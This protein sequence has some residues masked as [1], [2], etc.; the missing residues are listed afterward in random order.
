MTEYCSAVGECVDHIIARVGSRI[1]LG[2]PI[3]IG[4][5]VP[6]VNELYR[7]ACADSGIELVIVTGLSLSLPRGRSELERRLLGRFVARVFADVPELEYREAQR[8]QALPRNV[9]VIEFF[10]E[11]GASLDNRTTQQDY[12]SSNYT[13]VARDLLARGV[14]V[15]AQ[16]V[17]S[18]GSGERQE[19]SLGSNADVT[20]DLLPQIAA[21]RSAGRDIMLVGEVHPRLP[22]MLG[23]A[24]VAAARFDLLLEHERY[25]Y[26][27]FCPPN[28]PIG[29]VDHALGLQASAL[30][31]DG[32]TLQIG[33]GELGDAIVCALQLRHQQNGAYRQALGDL[34]IESAAPLIDA[35]GGREPFA[36]GLFGCTE[37]LIDQ[38]LDL[39]RC[40]IL[41]RRVYDF[42]PLQRLIERGGL[43]EPFDADVLKGLLEA[44]VPAQLDAA[45]FAALRRYGILAEACRYDTGTIRSPEGVAIEANFG[46][47]QV[48]ARI[49][50]TCLGRRLKGGAVVQAGFFLGPRNF[51]AALHALPEDERALFDMRGVG[52]VNQLY[53]NDYELR[54]LQ[55]RDARFINTT[56]MVTLLGAAVSDTLDDGR[57]V[58]GVGGQYNFVSMA[59][60]LPDARS[61]LCLRA[62]RTQRG[63]TR[64]NIVWNYAQATI[65]RHLRDLVATEYGVA[66]LRSRTD[67]EVIVA[68]LNI[69]D[70]RF[71]EQLQHAAQ[72]SGK[73]A[74]D[75]RIPDQHRNNYPHVLHAALAPH[76][77]AGRFSEFPFGTDFN[78]EEIEL[79][80]ALKFLK[81]STA[82]LTGRIATFMAAARVRHD[83]SYANCLARMSLDRPV[84]VSERVLARLVLLALQRV[85]AQT[86]P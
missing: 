48:R 62:T 45:S 40:G 8:K 74:A 23:Q 16:L 86:L 64:S 60:A 67:S 54:V 76:R 31:R 12:L 32:G 63:Q 69:A 50:Q 78:A 73:L 57:V 65:P 1:V 10:L 51:Y 30:I 39:Y 17:A 41:R 3:G 36:T 18:R 9:Q 7:R 11:P 42:L 2:V 44:G 66:D 83:P 49:A 4:K 43:R 56:M 46:D 5:P 38:M 19:L 29:S 68:L 34:R 22:F 21:A 28:L 52:H 55:R 25:D 84:G 79:T 47:P 20:A 81:G 80:R 70:S 35:I 71:Q 61:L 24:V 59:H 26:A 82:T 37:M 72:R 75:H 85:R 15:I 53:G 33:I 14:N 6:L 58:S 27:L 77:A 13:H